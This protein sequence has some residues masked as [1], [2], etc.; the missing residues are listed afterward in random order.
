M[1]IAVKVEMRKVSGVRYA[2]F[3]LVDEVGTDSLEEALIAA[4]LRDC[5]VACGDDVGIFKVLVDA[6][7]GTSVTRIGG[8]DVPVASV[9]ELTTALND[10][11]FEVR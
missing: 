4:A 7:D 8:V 9:K 11:G 3:R 6:D 5:D 1:G 10:R 2:R